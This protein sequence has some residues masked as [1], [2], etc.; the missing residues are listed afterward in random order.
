[1]RAV[2]LAV[3][4]GFNVAPHAA[5][6]VQQKDGA[7]VVAT[8]PAGGALDYSYEW[9]DCEPDKKQWQDT[10]DTKTKDVDAKDKP[11]AQAKALADLQS[12]HLSCEAPGDKWVTVG[13]EGFTDEVEVKLH[14]DPDPDQLL[15]TS[16]P[17]R[18][19]AKNV[20][21]KHLGG[22]AASTTVQVPRE[23]K[24]VMLEVGQN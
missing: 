12:S 3:M 10:F 13:K 17:V 18:L 20:F 14:L 6:T 5:A 4:G 21:S 2:G 24:K 22:L 19:R 16:R 15:E 7:W 9:A 23:A 8:A 11:S 1:M